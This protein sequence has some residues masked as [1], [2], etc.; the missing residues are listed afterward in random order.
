M[1][2]TIGQ[3]IQSM[4]N[5]MDRGEVELALSEV[6]I[7]IDITSQKYYHL[8]K[9]S[10]DTY[11]RFLN[12]N[13]WMITMTGMAF[14]GSD[15]IKIPFTHKDIRSDSEGYCTLQQ[16]IYHVMRCGLLHSTGEG[17]KLRWN[18]LIPIAV[19]L[20]GY[21]NISPSFIWGLA[22]CVIVCEVNKDETIN[23]C[24]WISTAT[25][26]YLINDLWG[27]KNSVKLMAKSAF[28]ITVNML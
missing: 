15:S 2:V 4:I 16:I 10:A 5:H 28:D 26:K 21:L 25:F 17:S 7:A 24:S 13:M 6:C 12:E 11:K 1:A 8:E 20:D 27:K 18:A 22:L 9:S 23:E 3:R 14:I 19:D